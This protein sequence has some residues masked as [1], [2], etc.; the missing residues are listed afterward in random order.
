MR[1]LL[2]S[3]VALIGFQPIASV[4]M[5]SEGPNA[6]IQAV[7][8]E[9]QY[10]NAANIA[11]RSILRKDPVKSCTFFNYRIACVSRFL[12]E[13]EWGK[14]RHVAHKL[15]PFAARQIARENEGPPYNQLSV[16][17]AW[18][19]ASE[20]QLDNPKPVLVLPPYPGFVPFA[21]YG[22]KID[23]DY[24][25][26]NREIGYLDDAPEEMR[27]EMEALGED[28]TFGRSLLTA[29]SESLPELSVTAGPDTFDT[30]LHHSFDYRG[31]D[32]FGD[33]ATVSDVADGD[34]IVQ[35]WSDYVRFSD[36]ADLSKCSEACSIAVIL[37]SKRGKIHS[38]AACTVTSVSGVPGGPE[39]CYTVVTTDGKSTFIRASIYP[40]ALNGL[41]GIGGDELVC[42]AGSEKHDID[43]LAT[44]VADKLKSVNGIDPDPSYNV[45]IAKKG[46]LRTVLM[47]NRFGPSK[48]LDEHKVMYEISTTRVDLFAEDSGLQASIAI[49]ASV[50]PTHSYS[51]GDY[52][53]VAD[54]P[55]DRM[56]RHI[57]DLLK[58]SL[59]CKVSRGN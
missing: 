50:S 47:T 24:E 42:N 58:G 53:T 35:F 8:F 34:K 54:Q 16:V 48:L 51:Q 32:L 23:L 28:W 56:R 52:M 49:S 1:G 36:T 2:W 25:K 5:A 4:S 11:L 9:A 6:R 12:T 20:A 22:G 26:M 21:A 44:E 18:Q 15:A 39:N 30:L 10:S 59:T 3:I 40:N 17:N 41:D 46:D 43:Q 33:F 31:H 38:I 14:L 37:T 7:F 55:A 29:N 13:R 27:P 57:I 19:T 45:D